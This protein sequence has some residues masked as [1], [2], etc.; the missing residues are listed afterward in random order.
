MGKWNYLLSKL[1][2]R[3][4]DVYFAPD[5]LNLYQFGTKEGKV[6]LLKFEN[7]DGI[8]LYPYIERDIPLELTEG[9]I[10]K[11]IITPYGYGGPISTTYSPKFLKSFNKALNSFFMDMS[12]ISEFVRFHPVIENYRSRE[13]NCIFLHKTF[14]VDFS[15]HSFDNLEF[16]KDSFKRGVKRAQKFNLNFEIQ[17]L[18]KENLSN[19]VEIYKSTMER[20]EALNYYFFESE[21]WN[22]LLELSKKNECILA[23]VLYKGKT[24]SSAI[25][26]IWRNTYIHYHLGGSIFEYLNMRPN[27]FLFWNIE[28]F[29]LILL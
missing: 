26:L 23:N 8:C 3:H 18:N 13:C 15:K 24:I 14:G 11:D 22:L 12:Y 19:F 21:Y 10:L 29:H 7:D 6:R 2:E 9:T 20:N 27:N 1:P 4:S 5:Y 25:F 16:W 28:W 17:V